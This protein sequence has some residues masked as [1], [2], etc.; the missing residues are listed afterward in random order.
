MVQKRF[1]WCSEAKNNTADSRIKPARLGVGKVGQ[2]ACPGSESRVAGGHSG[3]RPGWAGEGR[4]RVGGSRRP[5]KAQQN[6]GS[7]KTDANPVLS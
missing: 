5:S 3:S 7:G 2:P 6:H 4:V 1:Y